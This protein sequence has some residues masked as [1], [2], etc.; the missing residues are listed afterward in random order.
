MESSQAG[1][2]ASAAISAAPASKTQIVSSANHGVNLASGG[3]DDRCGYGEL[4][5]NSVL[6][7]DDFG[8]P[9]LPAAP[10][11]LVAPRPVQRPRL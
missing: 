3:G 8:F 1:Y 2:I 6:T 7:G 4:G 10:S 11:L 9:V 5:H